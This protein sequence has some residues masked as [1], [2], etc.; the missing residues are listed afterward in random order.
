[1]VPGARAAL[2]VAR[3]LVGIGFLLRYWAVYKLIVVVVGAF[4]VVVMTFRHGEID[5]GVFYEVGRELAAGERQI[6]CSSSR[7]P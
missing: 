7:I 5:V 6:R 2:V 1:M 3:V 4:V